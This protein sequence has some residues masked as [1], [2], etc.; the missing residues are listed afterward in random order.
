[1]PGATLFSGIRGQSWAR[2]SSFTFVNMPSVRRHTVTLLAFRN[3]ER[4]V[5]LAQTE[6]VRVRYHTQQVAAALGRDQ[7]VS[8]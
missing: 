2:Q 6:P 4:R 8:V 1:V 7:H 3:L 5:E